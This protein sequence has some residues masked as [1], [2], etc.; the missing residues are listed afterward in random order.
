MGLEDDVLA[1]SAFAEVPRRLPK[2]LRQARTADGI[3]VRARTEVQLAS[4]RIAM[5][6]EATISGVVADIGYCI[7]Y[8]IFVANKQKS[9]IK[10]KLYYKYQ[11]RIMH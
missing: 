8:N 7:Y 3:P 10:S 9:Y 1:F 11:I 4:N 6:L 5:T 2:G